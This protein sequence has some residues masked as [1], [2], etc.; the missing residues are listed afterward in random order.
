MARGETKVQQLKSIWQKDMC[1]AKSHQAEGCC[2]LFVRS[3]GE[4]SW[5]SMSS[6][7]L[8]LELKLLFPLGNLPLV[9]PVLINSYSAL[10]I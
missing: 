3:L 10:K 7:V 1:A 9:S 8:A 4:D 5:E 2:A 6:S